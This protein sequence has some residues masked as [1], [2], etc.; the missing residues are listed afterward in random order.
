[1]SSRRAP[2]DAATLMVQVLASGLDD[3]PILDP[4][5]TR[6]NRLRSSCPPGFDLPS[7]ARASP[8]P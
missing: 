2:P 7:P 1:M 3:A 8:P 5:D 4:N 6:W